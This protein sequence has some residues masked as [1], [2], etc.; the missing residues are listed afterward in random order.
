[1]S[2][3]LLGIHIYEQHITVARGGYSGGQTAGERRNS[4]TVAAPS[5]SYKLWLLEPHVLEFKIGYD[6]LAQPFG[7][8]LQVFGRAPGCQSGR[9][10]SK[11]V[12]VAVHCGEGGPS[13]F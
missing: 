7:E 12:A 10:V 3:A 8:R 1:M 13:L 9:P 2:H 5:H 6:A 11:V 4:R